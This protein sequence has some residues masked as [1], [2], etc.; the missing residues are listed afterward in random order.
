MPLKN[1]ET[2]LF[3]GLYKK[4]H[5]QINACRRRCRMN[6]LA[7]DQVVDLALKL[8][9][10][11]QAKLV[12]RVAANLVREVENSGVKERPTT[13]DL[14]AE[15]GQDALAHFREAWGDMMA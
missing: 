1:S 11:D 13:D 15:S 5:D 8:S 2:D 3:C 9:L 6:A 7:L 4:D 12:E 10:S 14:K